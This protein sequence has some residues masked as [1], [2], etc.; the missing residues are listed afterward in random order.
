MIHDFNVSLNRGQVGESIIEA[1]LTSKGYSVK[2]VEGKAAQLELGYDLE[3]SK[4]ETT[5]RIEVKTD[6]RSESTGN[7]YWEMEVSGKPGWTQKYQDKQEKIYIFLLQPNT[8]KLFIFPASK[9]PFITEYIKDNFPGSIRRVTNKGHQGRLLSSWGYLVP[10]E[11]MKK[12][13]KCYSI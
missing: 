11:H 12:L 7:F 8:R 10:C 1:F 3:A 2:R 13:A 4:L 6:Y 5:L 9:L